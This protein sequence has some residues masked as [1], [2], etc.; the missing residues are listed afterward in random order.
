MVIMRQLANIV[1][2]TS[3][4]NHGWT[5]MKMETRRI[6]LKGLNKNKAFVA[7][8]RKISF[9]LLI[10]TKV[11]FS[12]I[13]QQE[14]QLMSLNGKSGRRRKKHDKINRTLG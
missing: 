14:I 9:P 6:G 5:S 1:V 2:I 13:M 11:L 3:K 8:N 10:T 4:L 12:L 7:L